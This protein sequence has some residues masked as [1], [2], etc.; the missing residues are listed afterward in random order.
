MPR[1]APRPPPVR[2]GPDMDVLGYLIPASLFLGALGLA[3]FIWSLRSDQ[4]E[5]PDGDG[6][7]ILTGRYDDKPKT[8]GAAKKGA[9][10]EGS[11]SP[12]DER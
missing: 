2:P 11:R 5:D 10:G 7:R 4:Y 3:A 12:P 6:S 1:M 8:D 9:E